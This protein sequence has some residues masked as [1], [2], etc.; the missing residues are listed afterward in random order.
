MYKV[1]KLL[2]A[3]KVDEAEEV[4]SKQQEVVCSLQQ[5]MQEIAEMGDDV[6]TMMN[7]TREKVRHAECSSE[8]QT[9]LPLRLQPE[10]R[11]CSSLSRTTS[12]K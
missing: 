10:A 6:C 8:T 2:N 9:G 12:L 7:T 3:E 11:F 5:K 1:R 4:V